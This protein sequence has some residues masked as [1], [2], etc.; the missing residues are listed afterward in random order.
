MS[1]E[2]SEKKRYK[3]SESQIIRIQGLHGFKIPQPKKS[4]LSEQSAKIRD[5][6]N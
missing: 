2:Q 6:D 3:M 1:S 4:V 5:S